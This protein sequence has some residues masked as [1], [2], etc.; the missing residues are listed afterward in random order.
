MPPMAELCPGE[1]AH[2]F[3][4]ALALCHLDATLRGLEPAR[5]LL[6]EDVRTFLAAHGVE[7]GVAVV[8]PAPRLFPPN[9]PPPP[10]ETVFLGLVARGL[11]HRHLAPRLVLS[12]KTVRNHVS[13]IFTKLGVSTRTEASAFAFEHRLTGS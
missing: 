5:R 7:A 13:N 8:G 9:R 6:E 10:R 3:V 1:Q 11:S 12:E 4:R 2:T